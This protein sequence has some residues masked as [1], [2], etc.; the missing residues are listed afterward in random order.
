M[1]Y[2]AA[3]TLRQCTVGGSSVF[4]S[5]E[6]LTLVAEIRAS[7]G[8]IW[9]PTGWQFLSDTVV[10]S[11]D[12]GTELQFSLPVTN[13]SG[14]RLLDDPSKIVDVSAPGSYTHQY[15]VTLY[16]TRNGKP[17]E[18]PRVIGPFALPAD[19][20]SPVDL[21]LTLPTTT[22]AGG[23]V[24]VP[25]TWD[26]K[27]AAAEAAAASTI[28]AAYIDPRDMPNGAV[29]QMTR[30]TFVASYGNS[31]ASV[32]SGTIVH[33]PSGPSNTAA[34]IE[35]Q[36][37]GPTRRIG[38]VAD[39]PASNGGT[40][41]LV[42]PA[43]SW[44]SAIG[45]A[46]VHATVTAAG[47]VACG[48]YVSGASVGTQSVDVGALTG[49][50][51][52]EVTINATAQTVSVYLDGIRV[53]HYVDAEA[54]T[55]LSDRAIWELYES[56]G[57]SLTPIVMVSGWADVERVIPTGGGSQF[58]AVQIQRPHTSAVTA[59]DGTYTITTS[60]VDIGMGSVST[61]Y[62]ESGKIL[63]RY[64]CWLD[65]TSATGPVYG[66][67]NA[68]GAQKIA[69]PGYVGRV[70]CEA[71]LTGTPGAAVTITPRMWTG[72]GTATVTVAAAGSSGVGTISAADIR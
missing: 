13:L 15:T 58:S 43:A 72:A 40:L 3:I 37:A 19:D 14:W 45:N 50:H 10:V 4:E 17:V 64:V 52:V 71:I 70:A 30:G 6:A 48:R 11:G 8:L 41:A 68:V 47:R 38:A 7:R 59:T 27:V 25:D 2:P 46:G 51:T 32:S 56:T 67:F 66:S 24:Q 33:T 54:F 23:V 34:Y 62:P 9:G 26:A 5:G 63:A 42:I 16:A 60:I 35:A 69:Q 12:V 65:A 28:P 39:W 61:T 44:A 53:L 21:D 29:T 36:L 49:R 31:P 1:P 22:V 18:A 57:T 20:L 55:Y